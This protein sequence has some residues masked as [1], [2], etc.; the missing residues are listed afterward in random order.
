MPAPKMKMVCGRC[1]SEEVRRDAWAVW[2]VDEQ[3]W[4][5][6]NVFDYA[7]CESETC[8][9]NETRIEEDPVDDPSPEDDE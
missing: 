4:V 2:D 7:I 8:N 3:E 6:Q 5:L 9:G 1:G